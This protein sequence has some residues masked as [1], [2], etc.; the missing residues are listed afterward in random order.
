MSEYQE[1]IPPNDAA[2]EAAVLGAAILSDRALVAVSEKLRPDHFYRAGHQG[3]FRA[4]LELKNQ[5]KPVEVFTLKNQLQKMG[6]ADI[7]GDV[8]LFSRLC[9]HVGSVSSAEHYSGVVIDN[10]VR[11][12]L[13]AMA[14][15]TAV[16]CFDRREAT[17]DILA[18]TQ[19]QMAD[20]FASQSP[21]EAVPM[22]AILQ[23]VITDAVN[24][25]EV[26]RGMESG[27][28]PLDARTGG[29]HKGEFIIIGGRP[30]TGKTTFMLD[31][32]RHAAIEKTGSALIFSAEMSKEQLVIRLLCQ[33]SGVDS[34]LFRTG[35]LGPKEWRAIKEAGEQMDA[36]GDRVLIDDTS[37]ISI[38]EMRTRSRY[39]FSKRRYDIIAVDYLQL[40]AARRGRETRLD[41]VTEISR[42]LK[43]LAKELNVPVIALSQLSRAGANER[44]QLN[45]LRD[46]GAIEQDADVVIFL[47]R[48]K[49]EAPDPLGQF[50]VEVILAKQRNGPTAQFKLAFDKRTGCFHQLVRPPKGGAV[51]DSGEESEEVMEP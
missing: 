3:V 37:G 15:N 51:Q 45:H 49:D 12:Q 7:A 22:Q 19:H 16:M 2:A 48:A 17:E 8:D 32:I 13:I 24:N 1:R 23:Q 6:L 18:V 50:E 34:F 29:L 33:M 42:G 20:V 46:S 21:A 27:I 44:P 26:F 25:Q 36:A 40:M 35:K 47:H 43:G 31:V 14:N 4:L 39:V 9:G 10:Y 11:R 41:E 28:P 5:N 38:D 30:S